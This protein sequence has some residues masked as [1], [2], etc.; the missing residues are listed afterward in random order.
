MP[1]HVLVYVA[2]AGVLLG[3]P[4]NVVEALGVLVEG[5]HL[6][7]HGVVK[8]AVAAPK[9]VGKTAF[10][11]NPSE[12]P[13]TYSLHTPLVVAGPVSMKLE[14]AIA[15]VCL[16]I[17]SQLS[18]VLQEGCEVVAVQPFGLFAWLE[19]AYKSC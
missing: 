11:F 3:N 18:N 1:C 14:A 2:M 9:N 5:L 13:Y 8:E 16:I 19:E 17:V 7:H 15:F 10:R 6:P 12:T 4:S